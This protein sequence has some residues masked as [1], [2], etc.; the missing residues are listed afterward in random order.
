MSGPNCE[1]RQAFSRSGA[2]PSLR[3]AY[4]QARILATEF[5]PP[6]GDL[7]MPPILL[8]SDSDPG[9]DALGRPTP[10]TGER[11]RS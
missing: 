9:T 4:C 1:H 7:L 5:F 2:R 6:H 8:G 10:G 3:C 11:A